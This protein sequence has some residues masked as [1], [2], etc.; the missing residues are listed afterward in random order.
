[1]DVNRAKAC[2]RAGIAV[3]HQG[4]KYYRINAVIE[5]KY[6]GGEPSNDKPPRDLVELYD[7]VGNGVVSVPVAELTLIPEG[8]ADA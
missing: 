8:G 3:M 5:R 7:G 6:I 4:K 2:L 1:M